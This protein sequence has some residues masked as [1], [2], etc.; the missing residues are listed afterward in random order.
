MRVAQ[1]PGMRRVAWYVDGREVSSTSDDC[2][3]WPLVP[4]PHEVYSR[5]WDGQTS[6]AHT[7]DVVRFYVH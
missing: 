6:E 2:Y 7:T 4:G 1:V 3:A 5:I